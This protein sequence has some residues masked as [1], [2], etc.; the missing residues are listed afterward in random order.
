[1]SGTYNTSTTHSGLQETFAAAAKKEGIIIGFAAKG[2]F[3]K[4]RN[5]ESIKMCCCIELYTKT[6]LM[7]M[8]LGRLP[9][10]S[11]GAGGKN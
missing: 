2:P 8:A 9:K 7:S 11:A 1:M 3:A 4:V 6:L 10:V 5:H